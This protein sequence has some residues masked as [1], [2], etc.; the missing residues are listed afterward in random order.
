M[1]TNNFEV[2]ENRGCDIQYSVYQGSQKACDQWIEDNCHVIG[3]TCVSNDPSCENGN[4]YPFT[5]SINEIS[6]C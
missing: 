5:Y 3:D 2:I 1:K 6:E 4:G